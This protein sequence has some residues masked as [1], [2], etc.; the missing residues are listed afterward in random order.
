M[1]AT[2]PVYALVED[3]KPNRVLAGNLLPANNNK[4]ILELEEMSSVTIVEET[5]K[6]VTPVAFGLFH[7]CNAVQAYC[8]VVVQDNTYKNDFVTVEKVKAKSEELGVPE[9]TAHRHTVLK[10][11]KFV[12]ELR[13]ITTLPQYF[14]AFGE[15]EARPL[16][17]C[18]IDSLVDQTVGAKHWNVDLRC[19]L[20]VD[21]YDDKS[22]IHEKDSDDI[23]RDY[24]GFVVGDRFRYAEVEIE[25]TK[26][27]EVLESVAAFDS[28]VSFE[29]LNEKSA[30]FFQDYDSNVTTMDREAYL[31][32]LFTLP[33]VAGTIMFDATKQPVGYVLSLGGRILQCYAEG[34][35]Y[36]S[37][38]LHN[39]CNN[40]MT[41]T[42]ISFFTRLDEK[43]PVTEKIRE[44]AK[45]TRRIR[46]FHTRAVPASVKWPKVYL[47]NVGVHLF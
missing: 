32:Y 46:R 26:L 17:Q 3:S 21:L 7:Q 24:D 5:S 43:F 22:D 42:S 20:T 13:D 33:N 18:I 41:D 11:A 39:H 37:Q 10:V 25:R 29:S 28:D 23:W 1:L 30:V 47:L 2:A 35:E 6:G 34:E 14:S 9:D 16:H 31:T 36:M 27:I 4:S 44:A 19:N 8:N 15:R 45:H 12:N 38:L 40:R